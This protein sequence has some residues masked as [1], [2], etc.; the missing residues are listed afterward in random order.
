LIF[1][2]KI[3]N[4]D[5]TFKK[6]RLNSFHLS[7]N[8]F[9]HIK[10]VAKIQVIHSGL[11][12]DNDMQN[13]QDIPIIL[14]AFTFHSTQNLLLRLLNDPYNLYTCIKARWISMTYCL[15]K[16][17]K[18]DWYILKK[19]LVTFIFC[20]LLFTAIAVAV[21]SSEKTED[22]VRTGLSTKQIITQYYFGFVPFI[23][24]LL[25]PLFV[26]IAVIFFTSRMAARSEIIAILASG[27]SYNRFLRPYIAGGVLLAAALWLGSRNL[28]PKANI[29]K[30][31]F[32]TTYLDRND[33][34]K[35]RNYSSCYNC[36]YLRIDTNTYIG[37]REWDT[38]NKIA[39]N[40]FMEKIKN[41]KVI[42]NLRAET[43]KWDT[44]NRKNKWL[45]TNAIERKVDSMKETI[46]KIPEMKIN[47]ALRPEELRKD[48]YMKDKLS[49]PELAAL[50]RREE[51]R[52]TEGLNIL[53]VEQYRR[54]ATAVSVLLLTMIGVVIASR[55]SRGGSGLHIAMG[56]AIAALFILSDRFSTVFATRG[57]LAPL[58]AAWL[59]NIVFSFVAFWMYRRTPK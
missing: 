28:I 16:M 42:Y 5:K 50:I 55:R 35:N 56:I 46:S 9:Q 44:A 49:T 32:Q 23:W 33:P 1:L 6:D 2:K 51:L 38:L 10:A 45:L 15:F 27:I 14:P 3:R 12:S 30:T 7:F 34:T 54:T 59:P 47:L 31:N 25:F 21:D 26:F 52:G 39:R 18:L 58:L 57:N 17:L 19:F 36:F 41:G 37:I 53:K 43:I 22:L 8:F 29:I 48:E 40:F 20:M 4:K 24:G 13:K 11:V